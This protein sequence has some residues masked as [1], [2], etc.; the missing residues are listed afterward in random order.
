MKMNYLKL[1]E[2]FDE[3]WIQELKDIFI[4]V[5]DHGLYIDDI[6]E[7]NF[8]SMGD[9]NIIIKDHNKLTKPIISGIAIRLRPS[10]KWDIKIDKNFIEDLKYSI[11][12]TEGMLNTN[13]HIIYFNTL[14]S[15][16]WFKSINSLLKSENEYT[17]IMSILS[18]QTMFIDV[19]FKNQGVI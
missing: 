2:S 12:H 13:L 17:T 9:R 14:F 8:L 5:C 18:T 11:L 4:P 7:G 1:F 19:V 16:S 6:Y 3:N 15:G 10:Q